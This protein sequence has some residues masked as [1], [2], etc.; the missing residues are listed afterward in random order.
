MKKLIIAI[1]LLPVFFSACQKKPLPSL[2]V[3]SPHLEQ[4]PYA[5]QQAAAKYKNK[6][7]VDAFGLSPGGKIPLF[8][9]AELG[10]YNLVI[11]EGLGARISLLKPQID[12]L[13]KITKVMFL[14]TPLAEGNVSAKKYPEIGRYWANA[15]P[16]N[17]ERM[18]GYIGSRILHADVPEKPPVIF[19]E[20]AFY[21]PK[22]D[23]LF[24]SAHAY[25]NWYKQKYPAKD[26][27][28]RPSVGLIFYQSNYV[29]HDL[30]H[31]DALIKSIEK[32]GALPVPYMA[33]GAFKIDTFF[34]VQNKPVVDVLLY[35]GMFL[36]FGNPKKGRQSA[37]NL[38]VPLLGAATHYYKSPQQWEKDAGGFAP[39]MSDRFFFTERDGVFEPMI[40]GAE[41][42]S[43]GKGRIIE[44]IPYQ[45]DWRVQRAI[46]WAKLRHK[47]NSQKKLVFTYYS[48]GNGKANVGGDID[49]Y[50]DVQGSLVKLL[51]AL[52]AKGY[53]IGT[54]PLPSPAE[55]A[56]QMAEHASNVGNWAPAELKKRMQNG[57]VIL[58]TQKK[59][60]KWFAELPASRQK[61]VLQK[62][63]A[64]PGKLMAVADSA[65]QKLLMVPVLRFGNI[66]LAPHPNWGLQENTALIY[67]KDAI[68][69]SH[70]YIA[71]YEWMKREYKAD[72]YVS[73]FTQLSLMPGKMEGP[74]R[75]DWTGTLIGNLPHI[76]L[77]PLIAGSGPG[78]KRRA[79][80]L[81]IGYLTELSRSGISDPLRVLHDKIDDWKTA[82]NPA[83]KSKLQKDILKKAVQNKLDKDF[84]AD[85]ST[86]NPEQVV[87]KLD[88]YLTKME[89]QMMPNGGH[90][91]GEA[92][93]G[94][95]LTDMISAMLG[96]E[97]TDQF[98]G[99]ESTRKTSAENMLKK[100]LLDKQKMADVLKT[101]PA[102][103]QTK[104]KKHLQK[105]LYYAENLAKTS[106]EI[107]QVMRA[108]DGKYIA[109]GPSDDAIR[110]PESLPSGRNP[111]PVDGKGIPAKEAWAMG[112]RM[113]DQLL[114]QFENKHGKKSYPKKVAFVLWSSEVTHTQ[115]VNEAEILY[116]MGL[117]PVWN[118]KGQVMDV[119]LITDKEL[120][121]PRIDVLVTT[122]G[123][124]R[125]H[126][127]TA[128]NLL[129]KGVQLAN[130]TG[131][132][133][134]WIHNHT[135]NYRNQLKNTPV[136]TA[137]LR[138]YSSNQGA[139]ST[140]LE[141]AAENGEGWK[142][143]TTLSNLY[144]D[145]MAHAYGENV[146]ASYQRK[147]FELNVKDVDAAAFSRSSNAHG[148]MDHPMV[149]AYFGAYN[150]AVKN[151]TGRQP[152]LFINDLSDSE[153]AEATPLGEFYHQEL[154]SRYLNPKWIKGMK[155][156]G[157]D[158]ARYMQSFTENLFL[159]DVT[160]PD[161]V[162]TA[163]WNDV[164]DT[165]VNDKNKLG[166]DA[167]F[168]KVNPYA[169]QAMLS[170]MLEASEKGYWKASGKQLQTLAKSV[171][172][173]VE[174]HGPA[175]NTAVCNSP[176]L[177]GYIKT[178]LTKVP[179]GKNLKSAYTKQLE[180]VQGVPASAGKTSA[181]TASAGERVTGQ[182]MVEEV[183][184]ANSAQPLKN[185]H[186]EVLLVISVL[187]M[188]TVAGFLKQPD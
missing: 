32:Q 37:I 53:N 7:Q 5:F 55:L 104:L 110:N 122:S 36:N 169:K 113:A 185:Q 88:H 143:D 68:P 9:V 63:G 66:T 31:I 8:S 184:P 45:V 174:K 30:R 149:A 43:N 41:K 78:N 99:K 84:G 129:D 180:K 147:L 67:G 170:S 141:F 39:D 151:T 136:K 13:K 57:D 73:L 165:Y 115:G 137:A 171:A 131:G 35:G 38:D 102:Q 85:F 123:T 42:D 83:I 16:E 135:E 92:P 98:A 140:N 59:Y 1:L 82:A 27:A 175:C 93:K 60:E 166:L 155:A 139:Y 2:A 105:A 86:E 132:K 120:N 17:Y 29:K 133:N 71:F 33:K 124:Y 119:E 77:T 14:E 108:L 75:R 154:R 188:L 179:G 24:T 79:S 6:I 164:Y 159:W 94:A 72:A 81:T 178:I 10:K 152:D 145:R 64:A 96:K 44:P 157:Y 142:K 20:R 130:A 172:S 103:K 107:T 87:G 158:G 117:R 48:E 4:D 70:A 74:S 28:W 163:D 18:L 50:I 52:K 112:R 156:H 95:V 91:L 162:S 106:N 144:L 47:P 15:N 101:Y 176:S 46:A 183:K 80:A 23:T 187:L 116:L 65:G 109:S 90:V 161:M 49:A 128:I 160:T 173:S 111:Y 11:L 125:D 34:K 168:D 21:H 19:P 138:V 62:W 114:V 61:E 69:P 148:I 126:F 22:S 146:S 100:L 182:K 97:Y 51:Q 12:S 153:N 177:S 26:T 181:K 134:N 56:K 76:S 89:R 58:I 40:I 54:K 121:R 167:Y 127:G 150:L 25:L 118:S 3:V 186:W